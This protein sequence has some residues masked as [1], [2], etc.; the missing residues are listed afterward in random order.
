ML[1]ILVNWTAPDSVT[2]TSAIH[3]LK[4]VNDAWYDDA[5]YGQVRMTASSTNWL[6]IA[7]PSGCDSGTIMNDA[8]SAAT[9]AGWNLNA[10][11]HLLVYFP[12]VAACGWAGMAYI[13]WGRLWINGYLDTR[14][15]VHE[16]GH[17]LGLYHAHSVACTQASTAV[18]W[19]T[20]CTRSEYGDP[21][22]AM[23]GSFG[24][25]VGRFNA[26]QSDDLDW[27]QG[28]KQ[29]AAAGGGRTR[30]RHWSNARP[31]SRPCDCPARRM[32]SGSSTGRRRGSTGGSRRERRTA[33]SCTSPRT[34][35][36]PISST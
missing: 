5:S 35:V 23:G 12:Y 4:D 3:Q 2:P 25:G 33:C 16:L 11:D 15:T 6:T 8:F 21:Y 10:Y 26:S 9:A 18:P 14:V 20:S 17:N 29:T 19:S 36:V 34:S 28:R 27:M 7:A 24:G 31:T 13:G 32:T 22:D 30:S 1:A